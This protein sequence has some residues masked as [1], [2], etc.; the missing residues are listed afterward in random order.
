MRRRLADPAT[1]AQV[2]AEMGLA[3]PPRGSPA[4][5]VES[6]G[7]ASADVEQLISGDLL[8][9]AVAETEGQT[10]E[11]EPAP[12]RDELRAFVRIVEP[13]LVA[14]ADPRQAEM[15]SALDRATSAQMAALLHAPDFQL[16]ES[17][18]RA[19]FFLVRKVETSE[20]L[21]IYLLEVS[22]T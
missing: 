12:A 13:H 20:R 7:V 15:M 9:Q 17:A 1:F 11:R 14:E 6:Q 8:E 22:K 5:P 4:K 10:A 3:V 2:L 21:K 19:L 18:W 16:L